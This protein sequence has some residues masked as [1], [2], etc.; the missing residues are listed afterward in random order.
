MSTRQCW[1]LRPPPPSLHHPS[2]R[3][4]QAT[5]FMEGVWGQVGDLGHNREQVPQTGPLGLPALKDSEGALAHASDLFLFVTL[6]VQ[7]RGIMKW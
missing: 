4:K 6:Q 1:V 2:S 5:T 3:E 7:H